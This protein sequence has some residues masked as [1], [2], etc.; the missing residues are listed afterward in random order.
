[1]QEDVLEVQISLFQN[2]IMHL[3]KQNAKKKK[4]TVLQWSGLADLVSLDAY[5]GIHTFQ[6]RTELDSVW[7]VCY[8]NIYEY[9]LLLCHSDTLVIC[10]GVDE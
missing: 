2:E 3:C 6:E 9:F 7:K 4:K 10:R 8:E 1:M 5:L